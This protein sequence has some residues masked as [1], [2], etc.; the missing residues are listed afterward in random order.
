MDLKFK[1][2]KVNRKADLISFV[3]DICKCDISINSDMVEIDKTP[4]FVTF[5][6]TYIRIQDTKD[7]PEKITQL[8]YDIPLDS[9]KYSQKINDI[10][11]SSKRRIKEGQNTS[12]LRDKYSELFGKFMI[13]NKYTYEPYTIDKFEVSDELYVISSDNNFKIEMYLDSNKKLKFCPIIDKRIIK[14]LSPIDMDD[15]KTYIN[16]IDTTIKKIEKLKKVMALIIV[17]INTVIE[18]NIGTNK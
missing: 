13:S 9:Q 18:V 8:F 15:H 16:I 5:G 3:K 12:K 17:D 1:I 11:E 14:N 2:K 6:K 10:V 4:V 7:E